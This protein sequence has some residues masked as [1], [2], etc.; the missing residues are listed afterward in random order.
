VRTNPLY[1][2]GCS[3]GVLH[4]QILTEVLA[5]QRDP[6]L[7]ARQFAERTEAELR[8]IFNASLREDKN[9]IKRAAAV[10]TGSVTGKSGSLKKWF[11]QAFGDALSAASRDEV[12][13]LR[14][15]MRSFH[16]LEPP[17]AFLKDSK[18][19]RTVLRYMLRGRKKNSATRMVPGPDRV[20]LHSQ[21]G[22]DCSNGERSAE[23]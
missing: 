11:G 21:L 13:V 14:G 20:T 22:L 19:R 23:R 7:R 3:L 8:P 10:I 5:S 12:D 6:E 9:G 2:R 4:A 1:G 17:G 15:A 18:V 16:L